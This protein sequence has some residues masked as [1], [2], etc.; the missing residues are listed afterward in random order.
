MVKSTNRVDGSTFNSLP[1][2]QLELTVRLSV[3]DRY[4]QERQGMKRNQYRIGYTTHFSTSLSVLKRMAQYN[5]QK[6]WLDRF[7]AVRIINALVV[8]QIDK[9]KA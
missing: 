2:H 5:S 7:I 4:L 1:G 8:V 6:K 9:D 3:T